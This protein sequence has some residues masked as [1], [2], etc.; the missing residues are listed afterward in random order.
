MKK[1]L[2]PLIAIIGVFLFLNTAQAAEFNPEYLISDFDFTNADAMSSQDIQ[3]FIES[4]HS[5]LRLYT[6]TNP[7]TN[8]REWSWEIIKNAADEHQ[9]S[10]QVLI[11]LLQKEQSLIIGSPAKLSTRLNWAMGYAICDSCQMWDPRLQKYKGFR[12]QVN[13]AAKR[14]R[15]CLDDQSKFNIRVNEPYNIDGQSIT[16]QNKAT[17]CLY[18]YTP[19]IHGNENFVKIWNRWFQSKYTNNTL[20]TNKND[21]K[22]YVLKNGLKHLIISPSL[23]MDY[24]NFPL[25]ELDEWELNKYPDGLDIK[26][27]IYSL[28]GRPKGGVFLI[29]NEYT[30]RPI[31]SSKVFRKLGF[32]AE[33]IERV[34]TEDLASYEM[35]DTITMDDVYP[36][37][38]IAKNSTSDDLYYIYKNKRHLILDKNIISQ[39]LNYSRVIE[40]SAEELAKYEVG[41]LILFPDGSLLKEETSPD[42]YIIRQG[43][44]HLIANAYTFLKLSYNWNNIISTNFTVLQNYE[45]GETIDYKKLDEEIRNLETNTN[46]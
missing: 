14:M 11:T 22:I 41:D 31:E 38:I 39:Q 6:E 9:I 13:W 17:S 44:R 24:S 1:L 40:Q 19:H 32:S 42:V 20:L 25:V 21:N 36:L 43:K 2:I 30:I 46:I 12:N 8:E 27:P 28:L 7:D 3:T 15:Q 26:F 5:P 4:E 34:T 10:P 16:S 23:L 45:E 18:N 29:S 33:E 37:G 35:G